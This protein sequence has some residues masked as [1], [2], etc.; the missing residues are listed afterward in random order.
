[1]DASGRI[2]A[3]TG[4][5]DFTASARP[6]DPLP[7]YNVRHV[8][9]RDFDLGRLLKKQQLS[10]RLS[11]SISAKGI[12]HR[13]EDARISATLLLD[14]SS[15][16][17]AIIREGRLGVS[18]IEDQLEVVGRLKSERDSLNLGASI[19]DLGGRPR[20]RFGGRVDVSD[21]A[22][23][24]GPGYPADAGGSVALMV[25]GELDQPE[26]MNLQGELMA[27]GRAGGFA[28]DSLRMRVGLSGGVATVDSFAV[29]SNV[30]SAGGTGKMWLF[31]DAPSRPV[32]LRLGARI[33]D[34]APV[35]PLLGA[36]NL[37][38]DSAQVDATVSGTR[39]SLK[40]A[41]ALNAAGLALGD[42]RIG[43]L[44]ASADGELKGFQLNNGK[45]ELL[46]RGI[47]TGRSPVQ[48]VQLQASS[49]S[50]G[51]FRFRGETLV[52]PGRDAHFA[53]RIH[54][55]KAETRL[56]LDTLEARTRVAH[57]TL[58]HPV[59][60]RYGK[61]IQVD[62]FVLASGRRRVLVNGTLDPG[63]QQQLSIRLDSLGIGALT[64]L[65][66]SGELDGVV[67]G[68]LNLTGPAAAP[69]AVA[70][71]SLSLRSRNKDVAAAR[72]H[73]DW[74]S[75]GAIVTGL[76]QHPKE[77]DSLSISGRIPVAL[78]LAN[79]DSLRGVSRIPNG[80]LVLDVTSKGFDIK[81]F[82]TLID[83]ETAKDLRGR[84][85]LN[86]HAKG[87]L[88]EP[89]LTGEVNLTGVKVRI[90]RLGATYQKGRIQLQLQGQEARLTRARLESGGGRLD[91][92]GSI[93][94]HEFPTVAVEITS[95]IKSFQVADAENLR[96]SLSGDLKLGGTL[97]S[98]VLTGSL[99]LHN[100]DFYLGAK[101][102]EQSAE[103]VELTDEDLQTLERR[104]G[105]RVTRRSKE[106][107]NPLP[108]WGLD[109]NVALADNTWLRRRS[110]PVI[111]VELAG[112][113]AVRKKPQGELELFG[114]IQ[115]K[116]GR[117]FVQLLGRR[118]DLKEGAV[119]LNGPIKKARI[120]LGA[121]YRTAAT[122]SSTPVVI[123]ADVK[124]DT[125]KLVVAMGS[126]PPM[127]Q[128]DVMS[129]LTTGQAASTGPTQESEDQGVL[130]TG[131]SLAFGA[132]LGSVA[133]VA[134]QRVGLDVV[135]VLQDHEGAQTLVGGKYVS[136]E[137]YVGFRQPIVP[138]TTESRSETQQDPME[139]ELEYAALRKL[140]LN[141][142]GGASELRLFL[143]LRQ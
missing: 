22:T 127:R 76:L 108:S 136:P 114:K 29:H 134:G 6:F 15:V 64:D 32:Q 25:A 117:S 129:Y 78:S 89:N 75:Q 139:F 23:L 42:R 50:P 143:R 84:L 70:D 133:G 7:S 92:T 124:S 10:T 51:E 111:A 5:F 36:A 40:L 87:T 11:G 69:H 118:F 122:G 81:T 110:D 98:P 97:T 38:L 142:Q 59:E 93:R 34:V 43:K 35:A 48:S 41:A 54:P 140:L 28:V 96:S 8:G 95:T 53:V 138:A 106:N 128:A 126:I 55:G 27:I 86:A 85:S 90:P 18:L 24:L 13:P 119:A 131:A 82:E 102:L 46:A 62:D 19:S 16:N 61:R 68:S 74:T 113:L 21:L 116:V 137:L 100:T 47:H 115:P 80:S 112:K 63:G 52:E 2:Q 77:G 1:V 14:S 4:T 37:T 65:G 45:A 66:G 130:N 121:E 33:G 88:E 58:D 83:P 120:D 9:F 135:Q 3:E 56:S 79:G 94:M 44:A 73:L 101:N 109:L 20:L 103:A 123:T 72:S 99:E 67:N 132:A 71:L 105:P 26:R 12:G 107:R 39:E 125:G 49:A 104:F 60:I 31:G 17:H 57:W 141:V 30:G 91:A